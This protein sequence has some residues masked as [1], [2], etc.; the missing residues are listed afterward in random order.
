MAKRD[1]YET[2]GVSRTANADELKSAYRKLAKQYHPD[3][4]KETG[5][6]ERFKEINEAYAVLSDEQKRAAYD[7]Y[8]HAGVSGQGGA[9]GYETAAGFED[10]FDAFFGSFGARGGGAAA[11]RQPRR[12]ADMRYDLNI[13]FEEAMTGVDKEIEISRN[14]RCEACHGSGA[15]PGTSPVRCTTCKGTGEVRQ[16]RQTFLG[17]MVNV[18]ACPTCRGA[19]EVITSPCKACSGRGQTRRTR[20]L[21]IN[22]PP[23]I[24]SNQQIRYTG[25]GEPGQN[26]GPNG[27]LFVVIAVLP[28]AFFRRRGDD[29][30]YEVGV[31]MIHAALGAEVTVPGLSGSTE[32]VK[33]PAGTQSG[34]ILHLRGKGAPRLQRSGRGDLYVVVNVTT[35]ANLN[36]DQKKTL[37]TWAKTIPAEAVPLE[38]GLTERIRN[39][40]E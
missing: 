39:L 12:G 32:R 40:L 9:G 33:I 23:G 1:Y 38:T 16:V 3:I 20:R 14:E 10:I 24:D 21:V 30:W 19:G 34:T 37:Q 13:S 28:H 6:E 27:N 17:S 31:S 35:P 25:E 29:V 4:N 18:S 8:G 15:E 26:G 5:A 36:G 22:V 7:R 2:L 11:R